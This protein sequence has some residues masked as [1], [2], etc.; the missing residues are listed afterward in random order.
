MESLLSARGLV[1][2]GAH[3]IM[4]SLLSLLS[5]MEKESELKA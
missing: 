4:E 5:T 2:Q 1:Q 3:A